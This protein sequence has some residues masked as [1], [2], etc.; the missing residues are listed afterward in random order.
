MA[1]GSPNKAWRANIGRSLRIGYYSRQDGLDC[2][3]LVNDK[4][5]YEQTIDHEFLSRYFETKE[6][7]RE[8]SI[9]GKN[10]HRLAPWS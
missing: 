5:K 9:Y 3:W 8:R 2:I 10:R 6:I 1:K 4:G 7:S